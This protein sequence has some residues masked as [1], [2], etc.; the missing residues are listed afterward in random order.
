MPK[1]KVQRILGIDPG[2]RATGYGVIEKK[3][4]RLS[5]VTCGV[6]RLGDK[7]EFN[8]RLKVIYDG[9]CEVIET[10]KPTVAAV[11]DV[12]VAANPRTA[13]KLGHA[14]GA[15]VLAAL[16]KGMQVHDYTPRMVKQA[17]VGYGNADKQQ[18]QQMVRVLL[19]LSSSPS[20]DAADAL[21][22]AM[23]HANQTIINGEIT[24]GKR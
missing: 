5:Y 21:A 18:V 6:I 4:S 11:E 24:G 3:E 1:K 23:C 19:Q 2:S 17:V 12:F 15:A 7:Y 13:L 8:D 16:Q 9:L 20:A 10:H 14:R 22:V